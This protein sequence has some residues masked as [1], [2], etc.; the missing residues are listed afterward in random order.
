MPTLVE[1]C[2]CNLVGCK[3]GGAEGHTGASREQAG[4]RAPCWA[5]LGQQQQQPAN[6]DH[7]QND[8]LICHQKP[9]QGQKKREKQGF[10]QKRLNQSG[11]SAFGL[12]SIRCR[13]W[14]R[15]SYLWRLA[16]PQGSEP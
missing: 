8:P 3:R 15:I 14:G 5:P 4:L 1:S 13:L 16:A 6:T 11:F 7:T 2:T 12:L 10:I 9:T